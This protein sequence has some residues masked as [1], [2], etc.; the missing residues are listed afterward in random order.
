M[1]Q[2]KHIVLAGTY[3]EYIHWIQASNILPSEAIYLGDPQSVH[4]LHDPTVQVHELPSFCHRDDAQ[5]IRNIV[6]TV[7]GSAGKIVVEH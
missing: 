7:I 3:H 6:N 5:E 2:I 4:G 1:S